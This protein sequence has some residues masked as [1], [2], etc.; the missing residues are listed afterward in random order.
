VFDQR[1]GGPAPNSPEYTHAARRTPAAAG[2][3]FELSGEGITKARN[4][5][6]CHKGFR[7]PQ[8]AVNHEN[9]KGGSRETESDRQQITANIFSLRIFRAFV[10]CPIVFVAFWAKTPAVNFGW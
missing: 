4:K 3:S 10:I 7:L 8:R 9:G 5:T 6:A 1:T 2:Y